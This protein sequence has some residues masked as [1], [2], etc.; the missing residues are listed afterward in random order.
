[1]GDSMGE[2]YTKQIKN[3]LKKLSIQEDPDAA[4]RSLEVISNNLKFPRGSEENVLD[5]TL[6]AEEI[7]NKL[8]YY[9]SLT[10]T[11]QDPT[12]EEGGLLPIC[13][14]PNFMEECE[15][16]SWAGVGFSESQ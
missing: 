13:A 9:D 1:M 11:I 4:F 15:M 6:T 3:L 10:E 12:D 5:P 16:L 7:E 8:K 14:L 2:G